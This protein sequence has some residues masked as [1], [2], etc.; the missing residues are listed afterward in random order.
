MA[1]AFIYYHIVAR[2]D[3]GDRARLVLAKT[4]DDKVRF[5][6]DNTGYAAAEEIARW[7]AARDESLRSVLER[8]ATSEPRT[9]ESTS[10]SADDT[11]ALL[12][13]LEEMKNLERLAREHSPEIRTWYGRVY[14]LACEPAH[15]G[16][17][18]ELMPGAD[19]RIPSEAPATAEYRAVIAIDLALQLTIGLM[20]T[21]GEMNEP[22]IRVTTAPLQE[23]LEQLRTI[24]PGA[25]S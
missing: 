5:F 6:R 14:R 19:G 20:A 3:T 23:R 9:A 2:D 17:L 21:I 12:K 13:L 11:K 25:T 22:G 8:R 15:L 18:Q 7:E 1:E 16:D 24:I 10:G 4:F